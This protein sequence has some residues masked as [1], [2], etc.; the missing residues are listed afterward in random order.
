ME[1]QQLY[2]MQYRLKKVELW[3]IFSYEMYDRLGTYLALLWRRFIFQSLSVGPVSNQ[4]RDL[5]AVHS[6]NF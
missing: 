1:R 6:H 4:K 2:G 5:D 3:K